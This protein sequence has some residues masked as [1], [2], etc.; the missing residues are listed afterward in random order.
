MR[1]I[2][3]SFLISCLSLTIISCGKTTEESVS[4]A[5]SKTNDTV[6]DTAGAVNDTIFGDNYGTSP[7]FHFDLEEGTSLWEFVTTDSGYAL[8]GSKNKRP[9]VQ[10]VDK[11]GK[12][13]FAKRYDVFGEFKSNFD[14]GMPL[15]GSLDG[16]AIS[17]TKDGGYIVG[18]V[19][20]PRHQSYGYSHIFKTNAQGEIVWKR[21]LKYKSGKTK[22]I[23]FVEDIIQTN[24]GHYV[25]AGYTSGDSGNNVKG[26]GFVTKIDKDDGTEKWMKRFGSNACVFDTLKSVLEDNENNLIAI[27]KYEK[28]CPGYVCHHGFMCGDVYFLKINSDTGETLISK[29]HAPNKWWASGN[30]IL[31]LDDGGFIVGGR[32]KADKRKASNSAVWRLDQNGEMVWSKPWTGTARREKNN[33]IHN[34]D[35]LALALSPQRDAIIAAGVTRLAG[36]RKPQKPDMMAWSMD[37]NGTQKWIKRYEVPGSQAAADITQIKNNRYLLSGGRSFFQIDSDG[38]LLQK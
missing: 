32:I 19:V 33:D 37:L 4:E 21:Q 30:S 22:V 3:Y 14:P 35:V 11:N 26:Q 16:S 7:D 38:T 6:N 31:Q 13:Q 20:N 18:T 34:E 15:E 23:H 28:P 8:V 2:Y 36:V 12:Y 29:R 25:A 27:G 9:W 5:V 10:I 1:K 17:K 24:D